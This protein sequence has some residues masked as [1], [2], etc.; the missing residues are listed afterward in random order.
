MKIETLAVVFTGAQHPDETARYYLLT[1]EGEL[2]KLIAIQWHAEGCD[3]ALA[4]V[5]WRQWRDRWERDGYYYRY[6]IDAINV[7]GAASL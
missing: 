4:R 1:P 5:G 6:Y 7:W 3:A 2:G